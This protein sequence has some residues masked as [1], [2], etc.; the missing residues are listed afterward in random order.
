MGVS[1]AST[2]FATDNNAPIW[3]ISRYGILRRTRLRS[4]QKE[5]TIAGGTDA[6]L[7]SGSNS[8][9]VAKA[10]T[11]RALH[12]SSRR[13]IHEMSRSRDC[14]KKMNQIVTVLNKKESCSLISFAEID[15]A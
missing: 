7:A 12:V 1:V 11:Q 2:P 3:S 6:R 15:F 10:A 4:S 8:T 9:S 14:Q 13:F 5:R